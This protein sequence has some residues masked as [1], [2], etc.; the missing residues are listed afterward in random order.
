MPAANVCH[1]YHGWLV[2]SDMHVTVLWPH[3]M[4]FRAAA[5]YVVLNVYHDCH[6]HAYHG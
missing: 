4:S 5:C 3:A 6:C 2:M 1:I